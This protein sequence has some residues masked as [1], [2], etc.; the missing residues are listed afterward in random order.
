MSK[1]QRT[2]WSK[3]ISSSCGVSSAMWWALSGPWPD[4]LGGPRPPDAEHVVV[5]EVGE[6]SS[7]APQHE[8]R[9]GDLPARV[10]VGVVGRPGDAESGAVVLAHRVL[11]RRVG[12]RPRDVGIVLRTHQRRVEVVPGVD[13]GGDEPFGKRCRLAIKNQCHHEWAN[14]ASQRDKASR[15]GAGSRGKSYS[16]GRISGWVVC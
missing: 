2:L 13:I 5:V 14:R 8:Q 1:A 3:N 4:S 6:V 16:R 11:H 10:A 9:T 12:H 15:I 7:D